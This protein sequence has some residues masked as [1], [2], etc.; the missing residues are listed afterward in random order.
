[1]KLGKFVSKV[2]PKHGLKRKHIVFLV[3]MFLTVFA[4][5]AS[6]TVSSLPTVKSF[7][8][9]IYKLSHN[10]DYNYTVMLA[11]N[12]IYDNASFIGMDKTAYL[13]IA[14]EIIIDSKYYINSSKPVKV[15]GIYGGEIFLENSGVWSKKIGDLS[16]GKFK[17]K[18]FF[19]I[20]IN[21]TKI[22]KYISIV[23]DETGVKNTKYIVRIVPRFSVN[24][25]FP[26]GKTS[27]ETIVSNFIVTFDYGGKV[28]D[29]GNTHEEYVRDKI[30]TYSVPLY[31]NFL[32]WQIP[33]DRLKV[34]TY[35]ITLA[36][37]ATLSTMWV[38]IIR[39]KEK[40]KEFKT[41]LEKYDDIIIR[42][43]KEPPLGMEEIRLENFKDLLKISANLNKPILYT[44]SNPK[45]KHIF[46]TIG[47]K[48]TYTYVVEE[49]K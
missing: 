15:E 27:S 38:S 48:E 31:A 19:T 24:Y 29:F 28:L 36:L 35:M 46:W 5:V 37:A 12:F 3:I 25:T 33:V 44:Y 30:E 26:D 18:A 49:E 16:S 22:H 1:M 45:K 9:T 41:I 32:A 2:K 20:S 14:R 39:S 13:R 11:P 4:A 34:F 23:E 47:N 21:T 7:K 43:N 17:D 8:K 10:V 40:E 42:T 6:Y